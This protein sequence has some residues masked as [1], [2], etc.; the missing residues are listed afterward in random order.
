MHLT[1]VAQS[2]SSTKALCWKTS[3][4]ISLILYNSFPSILV[5]FYF[6]RKTGFFFVSINV[7][8]FIRTDFYEQILYHWLHIKHFKNTCN[9]LIWIIFNKIIYC[10]AGIFFVY[11]IPVCAIIFIMFI[12]YVSKHIK[13]LKTQNKETDTKWNVRSLENKIKTWQVILCLKLCNW[14][15]M[16][17]T[18]SSGLW[19]SCKLLSFKQWFIIEL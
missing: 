3:Q 13:A 17:V 2:Y 10:F 18:L 19:K 14:L 9:F 1:N 15:S 5:C 11:P 8:Y 16:S 4:L 12:F 6:V 7:F